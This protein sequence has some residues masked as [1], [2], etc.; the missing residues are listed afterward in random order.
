MIDGVMAVMAHDVRQLLWFV[1]V[2]PLATDERQSARSGRTDRRW[3][4]GPSTSTS[5][6][7]P[8]GCPIKFQFGGNLSRRNFHAAAGGKR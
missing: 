1:W 8:R 6:M 2:I 7:P 4:G 3:L 5:I